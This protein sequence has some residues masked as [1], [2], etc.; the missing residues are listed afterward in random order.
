[1]VCGVSV[2]S[3]QTRRERRARRRI[4]SLRE[5]AFVIVRESARTSRNILRE[6]TSTVLRVLIA[7]AHVLARGVGK[8]AGIILRTP[9]RI[10]QNVLRKSLRAGR[11][12]LVTVAYALS[13]GAMRNVLLFAALVGSS[14]AVVASVFAD[15]IELAILFC[16]LTLVL[17]AALWVGGAREPSK[18]QCR[19]SSTGRTRS[20]VGHRVRR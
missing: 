1:M 6:S 4:P 2:G 13:R 3:R 14:A 11:K 9:S 20:D 5:P 7:A 17:C 19:L 18:E 8:L 15:K 16:L 12:L 10:S